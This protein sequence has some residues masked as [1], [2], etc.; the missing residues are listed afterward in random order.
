[1]ANLKLIS[2]TNTDSPVDV[3][4]FKGHIGYSTSDVSRDEEFQ[5]L[6][7]AATEE[8]QRFTGMQFMPVVYEM[9]NE[10]FTEAVELDIYPVTGVTEVKYFDASN[11][12]NILVSGTDYFVDVVA[13]PAEVNFITTYTPYQYRNDAVVV[14]FGAGYTNASK[15]PPM[16]KAAIMLAAASLYVN[17]SD[18]VRTL[19]TISRNLLRQY[20]RHYNA[21]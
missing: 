17:P 21:D 12:E 16:I 1:M 9:H 7:E 13:D 8:A 19:P 5:L 6:L 2:A 20:R 18:A 3:D 10:D 4:S 14:T 11:E 15:V